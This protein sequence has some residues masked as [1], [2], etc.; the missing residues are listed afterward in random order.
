MKCTNV[1]I[2]NVLEWNIK[3]KIKENTNL[4]DDEIMII[5]KRFNSISNN[6]KLNYD[7]FEKSL[8]ILGTIKNAYL[9]QSIFKAF[10]LNNDNYL[11]FYEFC[12]AIN[13]MLKGSKKDK[14]KL[15][16]RIVHSGFSNNNNS[17]NSNNIN[18]NNLN[19]E[20]K[21][22]QNNVGNDDKTIY[23]N[24]NDKEKEE[25]KKKKSDY[26]NYITYEDFEKIVLSINDIKKKLLGTKEEIITSQIKYIFKSLS[27]LCEDGTFRMNLEC[28]KRAMKCNEFLNLL[29][30]HTK[31]ADVFLRNEIMKKK[32]SKNEKNKKKKQELFSSGNNKSEKKKT[33]KQLI[34][35]FSETTNRRRSLLK[36]SNHLFLKRKKKKKKKTYEKKG[37]ISSNESKK[38]NISI[39]TDLSY[40]NILQREKN[41]TNNSN[42]FTLKKEKNITKNKFSYLKKAFQNNTGKS[43]INIKMFSNSKSNKSINN[44]NNDN[45]NNSDIKKSYT[46]FFECNFISNEDNI[47]TKKI[48]DIKLKNKNE[49]CKD[50]KIP[51]GNFFYSNSQEE[52]NTT[53]SNILNTNHLLLKNKREIKNNP[54]KKGKTNFEENER[55][56]FSSNNSTLHK[57]SNK[58]KKEDSNNLIKNIKE[59][60]IN[61]EMCTKNSSSTLKKTNSL[62]DNKKDK[63]NSKL[64][65]Q[66]IMLKLNSNHS[67]SSKSI[68]EYHS[69]M[70]V[71]NRRREYRTNNISLYNTKDSLF[72]LKKEG[73]RKYKN[74]E[75][76]K[77]KKEDEKKK[78]KKRGKEKEKDKNK[79]IDKYKEKNIYGDIIMNKKNK[80]KTSS[81]KD[82]I[83]KKENSI[84]K[85][86]EKKV[87]KNEKEHE[88]KQ[89]Q[90]ERNLNKMKCTYLNDEIKSGIINFE[91]K[92]ENKKYVEY[93]HKHL[94]RYKKYVEEREDMEDKEEYL[95]EQ[96]ECFEERDNVIE[97]KEFLE[98]NFDYYNNDF[99]FYNEKILNNSESNLSSR[100][101]LY[102]KFLEYKDFIKYSKLSISYNSLI[103]DSYNRNEEYFNIYFDTESNEINSQ[104]KKCSSS[105]EFSDDIINKKFFIPG[106]KSHYVTINSNLTK[107]QVMYLIR[108]TLLA[109]EEYLKERNGDYNKIFFLFFAIFFYNT[110][111]DLEENEITNEQINS[112]KSKMEIFQNVFLVISIIRY[113]LHTITIS[114]KYTSSCDSL[115]ENYTN[116]D[117]NS[118]KL[119]E[120]KMLLNQAN[121]I[122]DKYSKGNHKNKKIYINK[123]NYYN[124]PKKGKLSV[125]LRQSRQK[126]TFH[127]ILA[128][129]F[130]HERWDLVMNM[131]VGI[132]ISAIK[133][134][135]VNDI[136]NHFEHKDILELPTTHAQKKVLFKNYA[137]IIF[138]NIR[139]YYGIKSNEYLTS[140]GP[141]QVISNMVLGN[142]STLS[143]LLS[144]GK[145]G[146]L[147]YFTSNGKY[148]IKT[149]CKSTYKLSKALLPKYYEHIRKNPDSLLTR[150]Y[151]IHSIKYENDSKNG[152]KKT[153][154]IVMNNFFSS[155]VEIHRR[156]DIKGS[157]V[158]RT[159]PLSKREDHTIA[160]K[161]VDIDELGDIINIGS[162]NKERLQNVLKSD[163]KFLKENFI[164]D[165]SLLF[166]IHYKELSKDLVNWDKS[167]ANEIHHIYDEKGNCIASKPFH[168]CDHGGIINVDKNRIFFFGIIDI[169]TRWSLK[170]KFEH[171]FRTLQK[172]DGKNISCIHPNAYAKRFVT[173]IE[174]HME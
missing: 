156:Y 90:E 95:D 148:I 70:E 81:D 103:S 152:R 167:K 132:R 86:E 68:Y 8:G 59:K 73:D 22:D 6:G 171:T 26:T 65:N 46:N 63:K 34:R 11:D 16:Y 14:L 39:N 117:I 121:E 102:N 110:Q 122:L 52:Y 168:Q 115:D 13:T 170:K 31:V 135:N 41:K 36:R 78:D 162:K 33:Y 7:K 10:D 127:K 18:E 130:G 139:N 54:K 56:F 91:K 163:T 84:I 79:N 72:P 144:E 142:L 45:N 134:F 61:N 35:S 82:F 88:E 107:E 60:S 19:N 150:L 108:N 149:V 119:N 147:F 42:D 169:F 43:E 101:Y 25:E 92:E 62:F 98:K 30:I 159:V 96:E 27:I 105:T 23:N 172:L 5:Y 113:F 143:E 67:E 80:Y 160:L 140:V 174:N 89:N 17:L 55:I 21:N 76:K 57:G 129:Y 3:K 50:T 151:G 44:K 153:Y 136:S 123:S 106:A 141:E 71:L 137:P 166:G 173:F 118:L 93:Y 38:K 99:Y 124:F 114:Q 164:L 120:V 24:N 12:V 47:K 116:K 161:D 154:F 131:M 133:Q 97:E 155:V 49:N 94:E 75:K 77:G 128:V 165:Y 15:S 104:K 4:S 138:K 66:N 85:K 126:K 145:S 37:S 125:S 51:S 158:G 40:I 157:L 48:N 20:K 83:L 111:N 87:K 53:D 74:E 112:K 28:Y 100:N 2:R 64:I 146:S 58:K 9:Y 109:I 32:K 1:N 29:G 69:D